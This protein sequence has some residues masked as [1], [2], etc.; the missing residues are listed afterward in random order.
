MKVFALAL[1]TLALL[2]PFNAA[3]AGLPVTPVP[4]PATLSLMAVGV[5]GALV[6]SRFRNK[7]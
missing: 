1:G 6:A 2:A 4:E 7:K 5:V 3:M